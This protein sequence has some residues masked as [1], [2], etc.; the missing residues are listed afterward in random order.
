MVFLAGTPLCAGAT[1]YDKQITGSRTN[2]KEISTVNGDETTYTFQD[3][4]TVTVINKPGV[5]QVVS[6]FTIED[7]HLT[8]TKTGSNARALTG[9]DI[10]QSNNAKAFHLIGGTINVNNQNAGNYQTV[11]MNLAGE[12]LNISLERNVDIAVDASISSDWGWSEVYGLRSDQASR[13]R[14]S[15]ETLSLRTSGKASGTASTDVY[16]IRN[17]DAQSNNFQVNDL[18]ITSRATS[19]QGSAYAYGVQ[20]DGVDL[21]GKQFTI[22]T[23]AVAHE[24]E[25]TAYAAGIEVQNLSRN[26]TDTSALSGSIQVS[27]QGETSTFVRSIGIFSQAV[28]NLSFSNLD[29]VASTS[30]QSVIDNDNGQ[31]IDAFGLMIRNSSIRVNGGSIRADIVSNSTQSNAIGVYANAS[32]VY[33]GKSAPMNIVATSSKENGFGIFA[34]EGSQIYWYGGH[35][36]GDLF[37]IQLDNS[38]LTLSGNSLIQANLAREGEG[39]SLVN[40]GSQLTVT[41]NSTVR[42]NSLHS[43]G[44]IQIGKNALVVIDSLSRANNGSWDLSQGSEL[45][46]GDAQTAAESPETIKLGSMTANAAA[47]HFA[48]AALPYVLSD[49]QGDSSTLNLT[50]AKANSIQITADAST[51]LTVHGSSTDS[52]NYLTVQ[53]FADAL[54]GSVTNGE[55]GYLEA[56]TVTGDEGNILPAFRCTVL[57]HKRVVCT[58]GTNSKLD[59]LGS[60]TAL[61]ALQWRQEL[62]DLTLRLGEVRQDPGKVGSWV[63]VNGSELEYGKQNLTAKNSA[64]QVGSDVDVGSGWKVG[65]ALRYSDGS[66]TYAKGDADTDSYGISVYGTWLGENGHYVD[67]VAKYSRLSTDFRLNGM[68]GSFKNHAYTVSAEYGRNVHLNSFAFVEPQAQLTYGRIIGEDFSTGNGVTVRQDNFDSLIGRLGVR[69]GFRL[70]EHAGTVYA[71]ASVL[72]DFLGEMDATATNGIATSP[73]H[74]DLGGTWLAYSVGANFQ[75]GKQAYTYID[76]QRTAGGEVQDNWRWNL[77]LRY[78]W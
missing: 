56:N 64:I 20:T 43:S 2:Y 7:L 73:I 39:I 42:T 35:I 4:D 74:E 54:G 51:N 78:V 40:A 29:I 75:L 71:R 70:P 5:R 1:Q 19:E 33:L 36:F 44:K 26:L 46:L 6:A 13:L 50:K 11:G 49:L 28:Q 21:Q 18:R 60:L 69:A 31:P 53:D 41:D 23:S 17:L 66:A 37:G 48:D 67:L 27:A 62:D 68:D 8:V 15:G 25:G 61:S 72:H 30:G 10:D 55:V 34:V 77:G 24:N 65:A 45:Y 57:D 63:R 59:A 16:G 52:N 12:S 3:N 14:F 22:E 47:I 76:L 38:S 32:T 58:S 9:I